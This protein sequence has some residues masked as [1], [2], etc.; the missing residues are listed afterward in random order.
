MKRVL[1]ILAFAGLLSFSAVAQQERCFTDEQFKKDFPD[2]EQKFQDLENYIQ[3]NNLPGN[4]ERRGSSVVYVIPLV[5]HILHDYGSENISDAQV[6]DAVRILNEDFR[7]LNADTNL[8][9]PVFK[10]IAADCEIE[11]RLATLDPSGN[12]TNGIEHIPTL[13]TVLANNDAKLNPWPYNKYINI[14]TARSLENSGAAAYAQFPMINPGTTDGVM[15]LSHYIGSIGT[16]NPNNSRTLTH[17]IGHCF[18]LYHVWGNNPIGTVCGDDSVFDTPITMGWDHCPSAS[19]A[20]IC[21][22]GTTENYQN[23][24]EYSYCDMMFTEGQKTRM[25]NYLNLNLSGRNNLWTNANL[26]AT[27]TTGTPGDTC[28]PVAD[29]KTTNP[30]KAACA[31]SVIEFVDQSWKAPI[32]SWQ[33]SFPGGVPSTSTV[34]NPAVT[35]P[36][37]GTYEVTLRVANS[38][39]ADSITKTSFV[40]ITANPLNSMPWS[41]D[42]EDT[43]SFPGN[44]GWIENY[45]NAGTWTRVTN[46]SAQGTGTACIRMN[47]FSA[48]VGAIDEWITPS[49]DFTGVSFPV[50]M[51]FWISN[52]QV[53]ASSNDELKLYYSLNCGQSW[54]STSYSKSGGALAT[55]GITTANFTPSSP[56]QWRLE[57]VNVNAVQNK[58][59][60]RFKFVNNSDS[61]NNTYIDD[62]NITGNIVGIDELDKLIAGFRL[63][64]NPTSD[65]TRISFTLIRS[66]EVTI[67]VKDVLGQTVKQIMSGNLSSGNHEEVI[68]SLPAGIYMVD[69]VVN[70]RHYVRKL[71]VS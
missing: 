54:S 47:N 10:P 17:E 50:T 43:A 26:I 18:G 11:F 41:E 40:R 37:A 32:D 19:Q 45:D 52:A 6:I 4:L 66:S 2:Y 48:P 71:V 38:A 22:I 1:P 14:W 36:N 13:R 27:G 9:I 69:V 16:S 61:G 55:A 34:S 58:P 59:N 8:I 5:F 62:I 51:S 67:E 24:M 60:V 7:K 57:T 42:F 64:P 29:F 65:E 28:I 56:S 63:F 44:D 39:G 49:I 12:C 53:N 68:T 46:A 35:Y 15:S 30:N 31:G 21:D 25:H 3:Q 20:E 23:Y 70:N 33:W